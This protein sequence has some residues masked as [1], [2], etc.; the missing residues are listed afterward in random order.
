MNR[1]FRTSTIAFAAAALALGG[2]A[3][4]SAGGS[5]GGPIP[6]IT[7]PVGF[8]SAF[9]HQHDLV[10]STCSSVGAAYTHAV[11]VYNFRE[12]II[13]RQLAAAGLHAGPS[14][15]TMANVNFDGHATNCPKG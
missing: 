3:V 15:F 10:V 4:A 6:N 7:V 13:D 12:A 11:R 8:A 2:D 5:A 1:I 9:V 14:Y